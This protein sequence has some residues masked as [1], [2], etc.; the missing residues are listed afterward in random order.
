MKKL[1]LGG[2]A[3]AFLVAAGAAIAQV[4][5]PPGVSP[6]T[7]V[8]PVAP[9]PPAMPHARVMVM[10]DKVMT[11]DEA[12]GHVRDMFAR[13]DTNRDG[14]VT[15]EE[16][17]SMHQK[18]VGMHGDIRKRLIERGIQMPNRGAA[19]DR[20][21]TNRDGNLSRQEF[22]A[23]RQNREQRV[24]IMRQGEGGAMPMPGMRHPMGAGMGFGGRLFDMADANRDGRV[25]MAEAQATALAHF[26]RADLNHDGRL[27]PEE[28]QQSRQV[29]RMQRRA[30]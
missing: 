14:F 15:R 22:M 28:R 1:M 6:G 4:A 2:A 29:M 27:T 3:A 10:S 25:S 23:A 12:A 21:D 13:F 24:I 30:S 20:L 16:L 5:P 19:F 9:V 8:V 26:D 17:Q 7:T 18:M 11:R